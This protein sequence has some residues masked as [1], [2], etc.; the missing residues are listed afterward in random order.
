MQIG[1]SRGEQAGYIRF[2][3]DIS[4][5]LP[6]ALAR[7]MGLDTEELNAT[8]TQLVRDPAI[9]CTHAH[10][11]KNTHTNTTKRMQKIYIFL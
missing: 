6:G 8:D 5:G 11:Y 1:G 3:D 10:A 2:T 7:E 4:R 9:A